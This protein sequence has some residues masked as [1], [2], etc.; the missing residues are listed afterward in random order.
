[1]ADLGIF[2]TKALIAA[3]ETLPPYHTYLHDTF[4]PN[5]S[6]FNTDN[7]L[8]EY[9]DGDNLA[10]PFVAPR[11]NGVTIARKGSEM[12]SFSPGRIAVRRTLT[13]DDLKKRGFGEALDSNLTPAAREAGMVAKDLDEM[14]KMIA[15][16]LEVMAASMMF[17]GKITMKEMGDD[18]AV[19]DEK[20]VDFGVDTY[21]VTTDWNLTKAGGKQI[22]DDLDAMIT[23]KYNKGLP[24]DT[25]VVAPE[26]ANL[27]QYN[28]Y[29]MDLRDNRTFTAF[30]QSQ[31]TKLPTGATRVCVLN[32][33]GTPLEVITYR[34]TYK[35]PE[36]G[37]IKKYIPDGMICLT[38]PGSGQTV[39]GSISQL[40]QGSTSF[41]TY[42]NTEV[43]KFLS[44]PYGETREIRLASRPISYP[45]NRGAFLVAK[46][47]GNKTTTD[48][49]KTS[50][51]STP[52]SGS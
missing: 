10:A 15:R 45:K 8:V 50:T 11:I 16:R 6:V 31:T 12:E 52:E 13:I 27:I 32:V 38:S 48:D 2:D 14:K 22:I 41:T 40:E 9:K 37:K 24:A 33:N 18:G 39:F 7:I 3:V 42:A 47:L 4:F 43:P 36:D 51:P 17:T 5:G 19:S 1:M 25:L 28:E 21:T 46:V 30:D 29:I 20:E 49:D 26:V 23:M 34:D 44:D 35:D